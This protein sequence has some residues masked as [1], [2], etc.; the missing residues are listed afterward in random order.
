[1][2]CRWPGG[3]IRWLLVSGVL[4]D[5]SRP[6]DKWRLAFGS[7]VADPPPAPTS[8]ALH[9]DGDRLSIDTGA[10]TVRMGADPLALLDNVVLTGKAGPLAGALRPRM[11]VEFDGKPEAVEF[12]H[13]GLQITRQ[14]PVRATVEL[15]GTLDSPARHIGRFV[16]R[17]DAYAGLPTLGLQLRIFND[18]EPKPHLGTVADPPLIVKG[19]ALELPLPGCNRPQ[20][21]FGVVDGEPLVAAGAPASLLQSSAKEFQLAGGRADRG[22][23]RASGWVA[24]AG[25]G[26]EVQA[27]VWRFWEQFPKALGVTAEGLSIGLFELSETMPRYKPR[28]G[29][30]KRHEVLLSFAPQAREDRALEATAANFQEAPRLF[31]SEWFCY[32]E[33]LTALQ[34]D[35]LKKQPKIAAWIRGNALSA[36]AEDL[37]F[38]FGIRDF[39]DQPMDD[40]GNWRSDYC[41]RIDGAFDWAL[42]SGEPVWFERAVETARHIQDIDAVHLPPG[43]PRGPEAVAQPSPGKSDPMRQPMEEQWEAWD[44]LVVTSGTDHSV[45][46]GFW[47][48]SSA[49]QAGEGFFANWWLT[50]DPDSYAAGIANANYLLRDDWGFKMMSARVQTRP[51]WVLMRAYEQTGETKYLDGARRYWGFLADTT[52]DWRRGAYVV[53]PT[54]NYATIEATLGSDLGGHLYEFYRLT[55]DLRAAQMVVAIA[56]AVISE[57]ML[58]QPEGLGDFAFFPRYARSS[59]YYPQMAWLFCCAYD[60]TGDREYLRAA[61]AAFDR[62]LLCPYYQTYGNWG[63]LD[64]ILAAY[65]DRFADVK[66]EPYVVNDMVTTPDPTNYG[67]EFVK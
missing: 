38:A 65:F 59:W 20:S 67:Y 5:G 60:L 48:R 52:L 57:S 26:G 9:R 61:R 50:G 42:A 34:P 15:T 30:A 40:K 11:V 31:D 13:T 19:L 53:P 25:D 33:A 29:E 32:S 37:Q 27:T 2:L 49:Y 28:F 54:R 7:G 47:R 58:P 51:V 23:K 55:G 8:L 41:D 14:G 43:H 35:W 21:R 4:P 56:E 36:S 6:G 64:P 24:V 45:H 63:W 44:G 10:I 18:I 22:G 17:V 16:F 66:T 39:A 3:G 12:R 46:G 62:Y 1:V